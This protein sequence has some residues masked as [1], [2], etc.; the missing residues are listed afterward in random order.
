LVPVYPTP[1][2]VAD[3]DDVAMHDGSV[4]A[5]VVGVVV[6]VEQPE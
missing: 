5:G 3:V 6:V 2:D 4:V 1:H